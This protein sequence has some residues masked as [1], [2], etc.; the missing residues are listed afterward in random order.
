M[1]NNLLLFLGY[2][3]IISIFFFMIFIFYLFFEPFKIPTITPDKIPI[4][5]ENHQLKVG[6]L[7][8]TDLNYCIYKQVPTIT[9]RRI[10]ETGTGQVYNFTTMTASPKVGC[11]RITVKAAIPENI[12]TGSYKIVTTSTYAVN[13]FKLVTANFESEEFDIIK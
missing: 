9:T 2:G 10:V 11:N 3:A 5:N 8:S 6:G 1:K 12:P 13:P 4:L 7:L